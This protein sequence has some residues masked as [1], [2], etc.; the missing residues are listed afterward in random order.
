MLWLRS[1]VIAYGVRAALIGTFDR[2]SGDQRYE[3]GA[4]IQGLRKLVSE[5]E[6]VMTN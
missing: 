5:E 3:I 2:S 4:Y 6:G 1:E